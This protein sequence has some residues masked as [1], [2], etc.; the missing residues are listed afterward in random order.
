MAFLLSS[1]WRKPPR[2][3]L[4]SKSRGG[5]I[6]DRG[7]LAKPSRDKSCRGPRVAIEGKAGREASE[8]SFRRVSRPGECSS[9]RDTHRGVIKIHLIILEALKP[10]CRLYLGRQDD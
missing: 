3:K 10:M 4:D 8:A 1:S 2:G 9:K 6:Q 7:T 5:Q